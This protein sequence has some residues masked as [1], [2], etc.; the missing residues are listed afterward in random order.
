[1]AWKTQGYFGRSLN[2]ALA[3]ELVTLA[4][5]L[6]TLAIELVTL[7]GDLGNR[8][9]D[10]GNRAGD[11]GPLGGQSNRRQGSLIQQLPSTW[12]S[13]PYTHSWQC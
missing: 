5:E 7:A 12:R 1:M 11:L 2:T 10:L 3:I 9:G 13:Q 4:I 8:A 6:V